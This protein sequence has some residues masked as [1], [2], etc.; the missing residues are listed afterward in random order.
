MAKKTETADQKVLRLMGLVKEQRAD[1]GA[2]QRPRWN[3]TC[4]LDLPQLRPE[5][6]NLQVE[7]D[8]FVLSSAIGILERMAADAKRV[9]K[10]LETEIE[11]RWKN[12]TIEEWVEDLKLRIKITQME[13]RRRKLKKMESTLDTLMSPEQRRE[14]ELAKIE[15]ELDI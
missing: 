11:P 12:F 10:E 14:M 9:G 15:E 4:S 5:R 3:T 8:L 6:I 1:I 7:K 13:A 2:L